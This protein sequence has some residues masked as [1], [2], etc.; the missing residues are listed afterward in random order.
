MDCQ[1][2]KYRTWLKGRAIED[3][4]RGIFNTHHKI[5]KRKAE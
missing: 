3:R 4:E 1:K 5:F 2:R